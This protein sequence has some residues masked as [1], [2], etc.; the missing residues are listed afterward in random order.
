MINVL[1]AG[2]GA[3]F[4]N[5]TIIYISIHFIDREPNATLIMMIQSFIATECFSLVTG[6]IPGI[7]IY[8]KIIDGGHPSKV[9]GSLTVSS[10]PEDHKI[11]TSTPLRMHL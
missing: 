4:Q 3:T 5:I 6:L 10:I 7:S 11:P 9:G 8:G 2:N 1:I